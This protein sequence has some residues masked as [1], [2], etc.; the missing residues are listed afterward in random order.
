V[1]VNGTPAEPLT[2]LEYKLNP[3]PLPKLQQNYRASTR[4]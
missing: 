4:S 1:I 3:A 2:A